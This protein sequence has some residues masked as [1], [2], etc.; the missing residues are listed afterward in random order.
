MEWRWVQK[1]KEAEEVLA[2][3]QAAEE[4]KHPPG[5]IDEEEEEEEEDDQ[6]KQ[7]NLSYYSEVGAAWCVL[8]YGSLV[9]VVDLKRHVP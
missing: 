2:R 8:W 4:A 7:G 9:G 3:L 1:M 5:A 6:T